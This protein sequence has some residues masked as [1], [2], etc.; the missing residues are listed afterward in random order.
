MV[1]RNQ[2]LVSSRSGIT[3]LE[4]LV[5]FLIIA[6]LIAL[7]L[8]GVQSSRESAR[9][10]TC[11]SNLRQFGIAIHSYQ[12]THRLFPGAY[13]KWT[14][15]ILP[16]MEQQA[17]YDVI[18]GENETG[19]LDVK[20]RSVVPVYICPSDGVAEDLKGW[21]PSYRMNNGFWH[22]KYCGNGFYAACKIP[23]TQS[24]WADVLYRQTSPADIR[25]GLSNTAAVSEKL[26]TPQPAMTTGQAYENPQL[27]IRLMR[28]TVVVTDP[29]G[30]E[31]FAD[32]CETKP[33]SV[34]ATFHMVS[35]GLG[36]NNNQMYNHVL[37]P[38]RN[39]CFNGQFRGYP[40]AKWWAITPTSV[41]PGGVNLL[42]GDGAVKFVN[43]SIDRKV[44]RAYGSRNGDEVIGDEL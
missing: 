21:T 18:Q 26:V 30:L 10:I 8:P 29:D 11:V 9:Q 7:I 35:N 27:W 25:D 37:P 17:I 5:V 3:I 38:N 39:S 36:G 41:H 12:S 20:G 14:T 43:D 13:M 2:V 28:E 15:Q 42:L 24:V 22:V 19:L 34:G 31:V 1:R 16:Y 44:W 23:Y 32:R 40:Y 33:L 6:I 4:V